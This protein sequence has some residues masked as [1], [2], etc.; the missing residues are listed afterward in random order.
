MQIPLYS[1]ETIKKKDVDI[2]AYG[3]DKL[4]YSVKLESK[5][6]A[7]VNASSSKNSGNSNSNN[8]SSGNFY[9]LKIS[10]KI[11]EADPAITK[12]VVNDVNIPLP[13]GGIKLSSMSAVDANPNKN[14][15]T[16]SSTYSTR[17]YEGCNN[18]N[19][20]SG[21]LLMLLALAALIK[22]KFKN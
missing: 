8:T 4:K 22:I 18:L 19:S 3:L 12:L 17:R 11:E 10:A 15:K 7:S 1:T 5:A 9:T 21:L 14:V 2:E 6:T 13:L 16:S 20:S